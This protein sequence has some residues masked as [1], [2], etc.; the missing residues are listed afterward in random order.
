[1]KKLLS[2]L[3][4]L[5]AAMVI[6]IPAWAGGNAVYFG[7][8]SADLNANAK[9]TLDQLSLDLKHLKNVTVTA[10]VSDAGDMQLNQEFATK[11]VEAVKDYLISQGVPANVISTQTLSGPVSKA[12][13]VEIGYGS[14]GVSSAPPPP[15]RSA[16][17]APAPAPAAAVKAAPP[18]PPAPAPA[19][20]KPVITAK[21]QKKTTSEIQEEEI[22]N[23]PYLGDE[24]ETP[25]SRWEY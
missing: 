20:A 17:P 3:T 1:M 8:K 10:Y 2:S 4:I 19:P 18:P 22:G 12:R 21:P 25:P 16:P 7:Y 15:V 9:S 23:E 24:S 5:A 6:S 13:L 11:R 14:G